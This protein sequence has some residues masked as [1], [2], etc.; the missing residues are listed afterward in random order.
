MSEPTS[1]QRASSSTTTILVVDDED[2]ICSSLETYLEGSMDDVEVL[3]KHSAS[4]AL[5]YL[6]AYPVDLI[7]T[8]F[9]MPDLDGLEFLEKVRAVRPVRPG[10]PRLMMTAYPDLDLA[11]EAINEEQVDAF[12]TKPLEPLELVQTVR[13]TLREHRRKSD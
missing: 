1:P 5:S 8:D 3:S 12:L 10:T 9:R 11:M 13:R 7:I 4:E 6:E 2:D